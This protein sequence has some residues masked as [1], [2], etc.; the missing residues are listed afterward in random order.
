MPHIPLYEIPNAR[1]IAGEP[2]RRWFYSNEQ[3]LYVW[4]DEGEQIVAFQLCY[5]KRAGHFVL[6]WH[7]D[8]GFKHLQVTEGRSVT[9]LLVERG[10]FDKARVGLSFDAL[11]AQIPDDITAF[12]RGRLDAYPQ[13]ADGVNLQAPPKS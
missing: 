3:D 12:V 11:S 5:D 13:H 8:T 9:P 2:L 6:Y 4:T 10:S 1:Q 7:E